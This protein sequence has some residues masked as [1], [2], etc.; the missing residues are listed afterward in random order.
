V[1][2]RSGFSNL[3]TGTID[4]AALYAT[5]LTATTIANRYNNAT[6]PSGAAT[7]T[8]NGDGLR[9][10]K[11]IA[12]VTTRYLWSTDQVPLLLQ[13][14]TGSN[15]TSYIYGPDGRPIEQVTPA[16]TALYYTHDQ[17]GSI[18]LLTDA[19]AAV[20]ATYTYDPYGNTS[21]STTSPGVS[22]PLRYAGEYTDAESGLIYMRARYYDPRTAKW[23]SRDP[24]EA[25]TR[26]AYG[27]AGNNPLHFTDPTGLYW[28]EGVVNKAKEIGGDVVEWADRNSGTIATVA[29]VASFAVP[30]AG[31]VA[32]GFG[33][34]SAYSN[35][36][37][38][39]YVGAGLDAVGVLAGAG[40]IALA[41]RAASLTS[42][43]SRALIGHGYLSS[44]FAADAAR[45]ARTA[46]TVST[47]SF[48]L[49][50]LSGLRDYVG[51][52][53][54]ATMNPNPYVYC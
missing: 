41:R 42:A 32:V 45:Y 48:G 31:L 34:W 43:S 52:A 12:G 7:Y 46:R 26:E 51:A 18:R 30:G 4:E 50:A 53:G 40:S 9:V 36:R 54:A 38:G 2:K 13:E 37:E 16:G 49:S 25:I 5:E 15:T 27:Y 3:F 44:W 24:V 29:S 39:D 47:F 11:T 1:L 23:I 8:Y 21:S 28:G 6:T 19:G 35:M 33:A 10:T 20:K 14:T 17:L 22:N